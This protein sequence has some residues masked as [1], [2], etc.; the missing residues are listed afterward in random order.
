MVPQSILVARYRR[1]REIATKLNGKLVKCLSKDALEEGARDLGFLKKGVFV[2][3]S[4]DETS[5]LMDYCIYNVV[6]QDRNAIQIYLAQNPP[7]EGSDDAIVLDAMSNAWYSLFIIEAVERGSGVRLRDS[8][9]QTEHL[10]MDINLSRSAVRGLLFAS[11]AM[12]FDGFIMSGGAGL[13]IHA[14]A[15]DADELMG[16]LH[17]A[18]FAKNIASFSQLTP[19]QEKDLARSIITTALSCGASSQMRYEEPGYQGPHTA[20]GHFAHEH[21][22]PVRAGGGIGRNDPCPCSSGMKYKKCCGK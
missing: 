2:F 20:V 4:E 11:R 17:K 22:V 18:L 15:E 14:S 21:A 3:D 12:P 5:V 8:L 13:P 7:S 1:F 19:Q 6:R 9:R 10:L 16:K